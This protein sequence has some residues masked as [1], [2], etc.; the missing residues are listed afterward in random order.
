MKQQMQGPF[1]KKEYEEAR[2]GVCRG[3]RG[4]EYAEEPGGRSMQR[5]QGEAK[6]MGLSR[7]AVNRRARNGERRITLGFCPRLHT[8]TV[9]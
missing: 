3:T 9:Y 8:F 6:Q 4:N 1:S 2:E 5:N 7:T